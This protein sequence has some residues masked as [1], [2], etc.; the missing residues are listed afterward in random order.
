MG[1]K[2]YTLEPD[3]KAT[4]VMIGTPDMLVWGDLVT[5]KHLRLEGFLNTMA[6]SF[7][8]LH[9]ANLLFMAPVQQNAPITR[10]VIYIKLEEILWFFSKG[11]SEPL[12]D[13]SEM[14]KFESIEV[15]V[16]AYQIEGTLLKSPMAS[17]Q[18]L[19]LVAKDTYMPI[20][21]A[22][23]SH[24][25]KPWLGQFKSSLLQVQRSRMSVSSS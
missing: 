11:E 8:P 23:V 20:Y 2:P 14:R 18:N 17:L 7:V 4:Q 6:E 16:G 13:E 22:T 12:P 21:K 19:L 5:K 1:A 25:A 24:T 10:P 15:F 3:Q 9:D